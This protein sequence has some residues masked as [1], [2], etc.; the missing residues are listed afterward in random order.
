[1]ADF[2]LR[3]L[4]LLALTIAPCLMLS[5]CVTVPAT[6]PLTTAIP[7]A[8]LAGDLGITEAQASTSTSGFALSVD[9]DVTFDHQ[10]VTA[11]DL[12]AILAII[13]DNTNITNVHG[14]EVFGLDG[15]TKEFDYVGLDAV[16]EQLGF[17]AH[18]YSV[19]YFSADWDDVVRY[20]HTSS[21]K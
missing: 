11:A 2:R 1:M 15:T 4:A 18:S 17:P 3:N 14:I 21:K 10:T 16:G 6:G 5:S 13:V 7:S 8:L 19:G 20:L 9:V 12:R